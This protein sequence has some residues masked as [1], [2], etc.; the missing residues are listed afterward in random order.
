MS[1]KVTINGKECVADKGEMILAVAERAAALMDKMIR[2][3]KS[4]SAP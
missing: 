2:E 1:V 4:D 3:S